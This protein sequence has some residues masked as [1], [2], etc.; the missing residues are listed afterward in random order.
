[1]FEQSSDLGADQRKVIEILVRIGAL[2]GAVVKI[3][4]AIDTGWCDNGRRHSG[5]QIIGA[6]K[7]GIRRFAQVD[8]V[9]DKDITFVSY[10]LPDDVF[11]RQ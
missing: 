8:Y 6:G 4:N 5:L 7:S 2:V 11:S 3:N 10:N 1:M 9:G